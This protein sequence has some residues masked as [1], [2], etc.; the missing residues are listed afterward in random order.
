MDYGDLAVTV[1][2]AYLASSHRGSTCK[3]GLR[4]IWS[5]EGER[6]KLSKAEDCPKSTFLGICSS[7]L[8]WGIPQIGYSRSVG[9]RLY[10]E[11]AIKLLKAF[12]YLVS[13]SP[14]ALWSMVRSILKASPA[15]DIAQTHNY[16]MDV[17][18]GLWRKGYILLSRSCMGEMARR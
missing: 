14:E 6:S 16:Q 4:E 8:V 17:V 10:G 2:N 15:P 7:G 9:N 3:D 13:Q 5:E 18:L 1:V 11:T 12:P